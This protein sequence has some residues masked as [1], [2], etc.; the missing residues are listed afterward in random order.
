M[1]KIY[2]QLEA[3]Q[4]ENVGALPAPGTKGR[5]VFLT[6]DSRYY[7]DDGSSYNILVSNSTV[8]TL[9]NKTLRDTTTLFA[10]TSDPTKQV[11]VNLAGIGTGTTRV[12][13]ILNFD[14]TVISSPSPPSAKGD[15][16][17][18]DGS[19]PTALAVGTDGQVPV[20]DSTQTTGWKWTNLQQGAKNYITYSNFEN[21]ATTGWNKGTA[22][23]SSGAPSGA[24]T[25]GTAASVTLQTTS[26]NPL[27]GTYSLQMVGTIT[28]GQGFISNLLTIDREDRAK[29]LQGGFYYEVASGAANANFS[30]T[31]SNTLSVWIYSTATSSWYQPQGVYNLVQ[32]SGQGLCTFTFQTDSAETSL[33]VFVVAANAPS[34]SI[35]VNFDD[36]FLG[37]QK[38]LQAPAVSD[39]V[40]Y[41]PTWTNFTIGNGVASG[42]WKRVGDS[43]YFTAKLQMGS[44][45]SIGGSISCSIPSGLS[46]DTTK[47]L[48]SGSTVQQLGIAEIRDAG[49]ALY[50][51]KVVYNSTTSVAVYVHKTDTG[52][53]P[54]NINFNQPVNA[55]SPIT[56]GT[57]DQIFIECT[58]PIVGWSSNTVSS[59]DTDTRVVAMSANT[60]TGTL[61]SSDNV[62]KYT[63]V[64]NDTHGSYSTSTGLYT[65]SVSGW[66]KIDGGASL[67]F[68]S[69][70][71]NTYA[72]LSVYVAGA[73]QA[74][75]QYKIPAS[76]TS[77]QFPVSHLVYCTAGTTLGIYIDTSLTSPTYNAATTSYINIQRLSGPAVVQ[78]TETVAF[79]AVGSSTSSTTG[80]NTTIVFGT[81]SYDT[82]NAYSTS[83]G[84]F[85][86]P[87]SGKYSFSS[88]L[89]MNNTSSNIT[90]TYAVYSFKNG[91]FY[92]LGNAIPSVVATSAVYTLVISDTVQL[93]AGETFNIVLHNGSGQT[94]TQDGSTSFFTMQRIGN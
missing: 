77:Q 49:V 68:S 17:T 66:Y 40:A 76:L 52:S 18:H 60:A 81:K 9:N 93:N 28:Q 4:V 51:G 3:A 12:L 63:N 25:V 27:S 13:T 50:P 29:V 69:S 65:V 91:G 19:T 10:N 88:T 30:G 20:A 44:T 92:S 24:P 45:S 78:A 62:I 55:T 15:I 21:N 61:T 48:D 11:R 23:W 7:Y 42:F 84:I 86:A 47:L 57:S 85:T 22:T 90:N 72:Y 35:T 38:V 89:S 16:L 54:V 79:R 58:V 34:G 26:T 31:S 64:L 6:T 2:S 56:F 71:A 1:A 43:L 37:P 32:S 70:T 80:N 14:G 59:A 36:F 87:V 83:T 46:I 39:M 74:Y 94:M 41:I 82:H 73:R 75:T 53:N 67:S 8:D 5:V 33:R